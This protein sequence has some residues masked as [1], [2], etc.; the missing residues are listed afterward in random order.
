[1]NI[2]SFEEFS[3]FVKFSSAKRQLDLFI[4]R[5]SKISKLINV[6]SSYE[7]SIETLAKK[8]EDNLLPEKEAN[9]FYR[10]ITKN[11]T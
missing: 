1:M 6:I 3:D 7:Y 9:E 4:Q 11:R 8:V 2:T 5:F 10:N